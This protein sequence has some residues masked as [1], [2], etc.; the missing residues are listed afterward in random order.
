MNNLLITNAIIYT[1]RAKI[2]G[3]VYCANDKI[4]S[5]GWGNPPPSANTVIDAE[6]KSLLPGFIDTHVHGAMGHDTMDASVEGLQAMA[7]FFAS[8]GVT[9]FTPTTLTSSHEQILS[10]LDSIRTAMSQ[11]QSGALI[12]GAHLEGP[13]LNVEKS[14]AQNPDY[15]RLCSPDEAEQYFNSGVIRI[16]SL[17]PEFQENHW[18][19]E[20]CNH[21]GITASLAHTKATYEQALTAFDL[22][23]SQSTHTFNAMTHLLPREPGV[24]GAVMSDE[25]VTCELIADGIH[26]YEGAMK[27]LW[28]AK[29]AERINLISDAMRACGMPD[30]EYKLDALTAFV[31]DGSARLANGTLAGS[32]LTMDVAVKNFVHATGADLHDI[33]PT[34]SQ[35]PARAIGLEHQKGSISQGKD[36]DLVLIDNDFNVHK[37]IIGGT[38]VYEA[39]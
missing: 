33:L 2:E 9:A 24:V 14:G 38:V 19:I 30:G 27:V 6:G 17:A 20:Q 18:L 5:I 7:Q 37:T 10:A 35:N 39:V 21:R 13:Y 1:P 11:P 22:G 12:V 29:G 3:W 4:H 36:A 15:V 32:V 28:R 16:V 23:L 25:R 26:V 31:K 8:K 34:F